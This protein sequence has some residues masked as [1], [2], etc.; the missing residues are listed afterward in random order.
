MHFPSFHDILDGE[1][2]NDQARSDKLESAV[3]QVP[4]IPQIEA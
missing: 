3:L 2:T 1:A 4:H